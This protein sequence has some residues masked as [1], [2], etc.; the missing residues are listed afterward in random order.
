MKCQFPFDLLNI[1]FYLRES[2]SI[3]LNYNSNNILSKYEKKNTLQ[4]GL[5][6][7]DFRQSCLLLCSP[8]ISSIALLLCLLPLARA[9]SQ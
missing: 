2:T 9:K 5:N 6:K 4:K 8:S 7:S 3:I 1:I